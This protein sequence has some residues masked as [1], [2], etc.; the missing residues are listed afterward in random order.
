MRRGE[1]GLYT[2]V[3]RVQESPVK[4][5]AVDDR[6]AFN[7][8]GA[9]LRDAGKVERA[10]LLYAIRLVDGYICASELQ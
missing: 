9:S 7:G 10:E 2:R 1:D 5:V 8:Y 6:Q 4:E 3:G